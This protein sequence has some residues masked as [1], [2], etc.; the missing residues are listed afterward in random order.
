MY[1]DEYSPEE[2][3]EIHR[4]AQSE[5][6]RPPH[7]DERVLHAP[8]ECV[9]CDAHPAVQKAREFAGV[10]FTGHTD[11]DKAPCPSDAVRG[12]AGAH[13]WGGNH[14]ATMYSD[15]SLEPSVPEPFW[16][17]RWFRSKPACY[18]CSLRQG[19]NV[20]FRDREDWEFHWRL[21]HDPRAH[22]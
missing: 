21:T 3:A 6:Y 15:G 17:R 2:V 10:N 18:E 13:V 5:P 4:R 9:F 11:P 20:T 19:K 22:T 8:G 16:V 12:V 14:P 1:P 7:C